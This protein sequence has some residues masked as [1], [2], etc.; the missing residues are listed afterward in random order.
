[1]RWTEAEIGDQGGRTFLVTGA[2]SGLGFEMT[3]AL[4]AKGARV[5][6]AVRSETKGRAA[7]AALPGRERAEL[8]IV[9]LAD[10]DT[11]RRLAD[12]LRRAGAAI[13]VLVN[14]A[15]VMMPPRT[16]SAQGH[17]LQFAA[18]HLGHFALT[19]L[20]LDLVG[21]RVVTVSSSLHRSGSIHY[22][23]LDGAKGYAPGKYYSQS[24]FANVLFGLE[25]DRRLR[26]AGSPVR[27]VL[28]HPG[29]SATNLQTSGPT[30][31]LKALM[32]VGNAV[33]AQPAA[34]GALNQLYAAVDPRAEG[35]QFIGPDGMR[36]SR[37][38]PT[39]VEPVGTATDPADAQR[40]WTL[41]E[42]LTGVQF[43]VARSR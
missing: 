15:G 29:Y 23:D 16:L 8:R 28:A 38:W 4:L 43:E 9:D 6:M 14:N 41:S 25:L 10:L 33:M 34:R 42:Q 32:R 3:R 13:D 5:I 36:E 21:D 39:V 20:L 11:V 24:K 31:V 27:S 17:E 26:A 40:L 37:G 18:N 2:N 19:G 22:D 30:G 7:L 1:M 12:D 35:G